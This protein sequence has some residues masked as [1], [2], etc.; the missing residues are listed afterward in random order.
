MTEEEIGK[1]NRKL[2]KMIDKS[3][4]VSSKIETVV[5]NVFSTLNSPRMNRLHVICWLVYKNHVLHWVFYK[6][7]GLEKQSIIYGDLLL[8]KTYQQQPKVC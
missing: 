1:V 6:K 3:E 8:M 5:S 7:L 4:V 2:Q